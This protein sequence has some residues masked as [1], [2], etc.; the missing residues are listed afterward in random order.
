MQGGRGG[1]HKIRAHFFSFLVK[2]IAHLVAVSHDIILC[3]HGG[4]III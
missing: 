4:I 2:I 3:D 1:P